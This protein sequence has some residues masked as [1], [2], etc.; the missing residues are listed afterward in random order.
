MPRE[1]RSARTQ[2]IEQFL[3]SNS[4]AFTCLGITLAVFVSRK[5]LILPVAIALMLVQE[6]LADA[7]LER[8]E[9]LVRG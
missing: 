9:R 5:F 4:A 3:T 1:M 2:T 8:A 7:G 6:K